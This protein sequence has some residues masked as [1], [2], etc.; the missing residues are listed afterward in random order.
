[1]SFVLTQRAALTGRLKGWSGGK[2][3]KTYNC[4]LI[5]SVGVTANKL[6]VTPA[7]NP[8]NAARGPVTL[9][10]ASARRRLY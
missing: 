3:G 8:A 7:A 9:P 4:V 5:L 6:S 1:M 2:G 10:L